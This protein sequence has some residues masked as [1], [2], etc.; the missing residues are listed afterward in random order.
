AQD[1]HG[2]IENCFRII[3]HIFRFRQTCKQNGAIKNHSGETWSLG[4]AAIVSRETYAR[5]PGH[6]PLYMRD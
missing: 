1:A 3:A 2:W 6:C 4:R 5:K